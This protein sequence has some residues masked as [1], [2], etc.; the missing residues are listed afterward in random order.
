[1]Y[2]FDGKKYTTQVI[3]VMG[4]DAALVGSEL[5]TLQNCLSIPTSRVFLDCLTLDYGTGWSC[6]KIGSY[7]PT[8]LNI[9][10]N[11]VPQLNVADVLLSCTVIFNES[12]LALPVNSSTETYPLILNILS[13]K[14][15]I[16]KHFLVAGL[17]IL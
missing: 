7:Q 1:M 14:R 3:D 9:P 10:E 8:L 12:S 13:Q 2:D 17:S 11:R 4:C 6:R 5:P 16:V 15:K